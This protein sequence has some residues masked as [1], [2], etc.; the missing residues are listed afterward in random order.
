M[1]LSAREETLVERGRDNYNNIKKN[2]VFFFSPYDILPVYLGHPMIYI[3]S[4]I[5]YVTKF[6]FRKKYI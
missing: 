6:T 3:Y 1:A 2:C 5:I 4:S